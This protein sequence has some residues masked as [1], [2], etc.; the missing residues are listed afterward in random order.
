LLS[1]SFEARKIDNWK[2]DN[3]YVEIIFK[4]ILNSG[5]YRKYI[6]K[7]ETS[8][9]ED[10]EFL[11]AIFKNII[12]PNDKLYEYFEDKNITWIDDF[13]VVNTL[14]V[15][16]LKKIKPDNFQG[17]MLPDL[18]KDEEDKDFGLDLLKNTLSDLPALND[19]IIGKT[20]NWDKDR[21][22]N[23]DLVLLQLAITE[24]QRFPTIPI[25]VTINEYLEI[26]KEYSTPK[27]SVFINGI[28]DKLVKEYEAKGKLNKSGRGLK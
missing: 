20:T 27:S 3:E 8:F 11:L 9:D 22:A 17:I 2:L 12:A 13:P 21:I 24:F 28:L 14:I 16:I 18:Y 19:E 6:L 26:A 23:V 4:A 10:Q 7:G 15:K 1:Q 5:I 25:K